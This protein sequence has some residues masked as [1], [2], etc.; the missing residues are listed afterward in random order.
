MRNMLALAAFALLIFA[1]VGWY[2]DWYNVSKSASANGH[3]GV[4]IDIN[5]S[6]IISDVSKGI[7]KLEEKRQSRSEGQAEGPAS[8]AN[9]VADKTSAPPR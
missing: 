4:N 8:G 2:F 1:G 7:Q 6:K 5:S 9:V 3:T